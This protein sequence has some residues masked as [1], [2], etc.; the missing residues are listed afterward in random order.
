[1]PPGGSLRSIVIDL[2]ITS[3]TRTFKI[4]TQE[5]LQEFTIE[6]STTAA[7]AGSITLFDEGDVL[8]DLFLIA[9]IN[10]GV[11]LRWNWSDFGLE[12][13]PL[14]RGSILRYTPTFM[15]QGIQF[16]LEI[17]PALLLNTVLDKRIRAYPPG[18]L[19]SDIV[20][21]IANERGWPTVDFRGN[22]TIE[23][24]GLSVD[25][26]FS[27]TDESD[28]KFISQQLLPQAVNAAGVG[29]YSFYFDTYGAVHFHTK[30]FLPPKMKRYTFA[31][32]IAGEVLAFT[33]SDTSA[34]AMLAGGGNLVVRSQSSLDAAQ[35]AKDGTVDGGLEGD[36]EIVEE[37]STAVVDYGD[38][39]HSSINVMTR[40]AE[41]LS[42]VAKF[43]RERAKDYFFLA[44][45]QA[46]GTH[47]TEPFDYLDVQYVR[48]NGQPH[49]MSGRFR[50]LKVQHSVSTAGWNTTFGLSRDGLQPQG[51]GTIN[52]NNVV[53]IAPSES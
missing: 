27:T 15:P 34:L 45:L 22:S 32:D 40:D 38:T 30:A 5:F 4:P 39:L 2:E 28:V 18:S 14:L 43:Q 49:Y 50:T 13:A 29:G 20:E 23:P 25:Q 53:T 51:E 36:P 10:R 8:E 46:I 24:T 7:W 52:R 31:R 48:R 1:M 47:D 19:I 21:Q 11:N 26:A 37:T 41:E 3:G 35:T 17:I 9:G 42:R 44:E 33:P 12:D 6:S 16:V